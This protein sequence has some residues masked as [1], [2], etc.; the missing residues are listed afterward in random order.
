MALGICGP[1]EECFAD[2]GA[3]PWHHD[4]FKASC[5]SLSAEGAHFAQVDM[6]VTCRPVLADRV[7]EYKLVQLPDLI[8]DNGLL[9]LEIV[10]GV[11]VFN[12]GFGQI[13]L[14]L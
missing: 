2:S 14:R 10:L 4:V 1:R 5:R 6:E 7:G 9:D 11:G 8:G 3:F 13:Q 12:L